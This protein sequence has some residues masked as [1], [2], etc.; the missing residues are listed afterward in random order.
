MSVGGSCAF[1]G[2]KRPHMYNSPVCYKHMGQKPKPKK[3][4]VTEAN[5]PSGE[6]LWWTED[7][8][9]Q[10][11]DDNPDLHYG[12]CEFDTYD[13]ICFHCKNLVH[14]DLHLIHLI[15]ND[16]NL[17]LNFEEDLV[18][19]HSWGGHYRSRLSGIWEEFEERDIMFE[20]Q[21]GHGASRAKAIQELC[22]ADKEHILS[23][24]KENLSKAGAPTEG[25]GTEPWV[26]N[27][28]E[29]ELEEHFER[30]RD[31]DIARVDWSPGDWHLEKPDIVDLSTESGN[32]VEKMPT[33]VPFLLAWPLLALWLVSAFG[34]VELL[35]P[36]VSTGVLQTPWGNVQQG[37]YEW[38]DYVYTACWDVPEWIYEGDHCKTFDTQEE[39]MEYSLFLAFWIIMSLFLAFTIVRHLQSNRAQR[40]TIDSAE[41][42]STH[43]L[44]Q[45]DMH[46]KMSIST[47]ALVIALIAPWWGYSSGF[48]A[49]R[50]A[51]QEAWFVLTEARL[52]NLP[53]LNYVHWQMSTL[54]PLVFVAT[55][56]ATWYKFREGDEEFGRKASNFHLSFFAVW[57]LIGIYNWGEFLPNEWNYAVFIAAA[58]GIGLH[59]TA[60]G[61]EE[62]FSNAT[63]E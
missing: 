24:L 25:E 13:G 52:Y 11:C 40:P 5:R 44:K 17:F 31:W 41:G 49:L 15:H 10:R 61:L 12:L 60:Y 51:P 1:E 33:I 4:Q 35:G 53:F 8:E 2:C 50:W 63:S 36:W 21:L 18:A 34:E 38:Q 29:G 3:K 6:D 26:W 28:L 43:K 62:K 14:P 32:E 23:V 46:K 27:S 54:L 55:V 19:G 45:G 47:V 9:T 37:Y 48:Q 22:Y 20:A 56:V 39:T 7:D 57:Y 59:P 42:E 16:R 58:S 30:I